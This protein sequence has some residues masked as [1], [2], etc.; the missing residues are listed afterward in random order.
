MNDVNILSV[1]GLD[2]NDRPIS[3][4]EIS[5]SVGG[6]PTANLVPVTG[7]SVERRTHNSE[8]VSSLTYGDPGKLVI[9]TDRG[10]FDLFHGRVSGVGVSASPGGFSS[11]ST[12]TT[13]IQLA[14]N[15][16]ALDGVVLGVRE[17]TN[18]S[19]R[20]DVFRNKEAH[21]D[22]LYATFENLL[23]TDALRRL[24]LGVHAR[25]ITHIFSE[26]Y[27]NTIGEADV[28][29]LVKA[30]AVACSGIESNHRDKLEGSA[31]DTTI[32]AITGA[33]ASKTSL[34][35]ILRSMAEQFFLRSIPRLQDV[36]LVPNAPGMVFDNGLRFG[37]EHVL[38]VSDV[39]RI[40]ALPTTRVC[41]YMVRPA[42]HMAEQEI[43]PEYTVD[44]RGTRGGHDYYY[45]PRK[46]SASDSL[47]MLSVPPIL[48]NIMSSILTE[49][50]DHPAH[51]PIDRLMCVDGGEVFDDLSSRD[52]TGS[53]AIS[54]S[55]GEAV[56]VGDMAA[57][58]LYC[59]YAYQERQATI[60]LAPGY[61]FSERFR[62]DLQRAGERWEDG[63]IFGLL[64]KTVSFQSPYADN[65]ATTR[66]VMVGNVNSV[67]VNVNTTSPL[68]DVI[69][70]L[71]HVRTEK[72]DRLHSLKT[73]QHPLYPNL[74]GPLK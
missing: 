65:V 51:S 19:L 55:P 6:L 34:W 58:M 47:I 60:S 42:Q 10:S 20:R 7:E 11:P 35:Q 62:R 28:K 15:A 71:T 39:R 4:A 30:V 18:N 59:A 12:S 31:A 16:A 36:V 50:G 44:P 49:G 45:Y 17:F 23:Y 70:N 72:M 57:R 14:H 53:P 8:W 68:L 69:L 52:L 61:V 38:S 73:G 13:A 33:M 46:S 40:P 41:V 21:K 5:F 25:D 24:E 3:A 66:Q 32:R 2:L 56:L 43:N 74:Q 9:T 67:R 27:Q 63:S 54:Q 64:G 29:G 37:N 48:R 1:T 26:W 22:H